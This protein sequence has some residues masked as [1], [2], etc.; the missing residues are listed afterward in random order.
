MNH[1][2][3]FRRETFSETKQIAFIFNRKSGDV[4]LCEI[5]AEKSFMLAPEAIVELMPLAIRRIYRQ[6]EAGEIHFTEISEKQVLVCVKSLMQ[7]IEKE[8]LEIEER[9]NGYEIL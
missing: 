1:K 5:C 8:I 9:D 3:T 7:T 4:R 6:I 2:R